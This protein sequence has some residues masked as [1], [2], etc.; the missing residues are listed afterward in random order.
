MGTAG[1]RRLQFIRAHMSLSS[2]SVSPCTRV[3]SPAAGWPPLQPPKFPSFTLWA[4]HP[5]GS[6]DQQQKI[7]P[8]PFLGKNYNCVK[9]VLVPISGPNTRGDKDGYLN[10]P[11]SVRCPPLS[12]FILARGSTWNNIAA[13][14]TAMWRARLLQ[15]RGGILDTSGFS[16]HYRQ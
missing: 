9:L 11:A 1:T 12:W 4:F 6:A 2:I 5:Q 7:L 16:P 8:T 15:E 10:G 13:T 3:I 14:T